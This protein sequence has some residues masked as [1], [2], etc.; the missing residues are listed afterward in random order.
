MKMVGKKQKISKK[1][2]GQICKTRWPNKNIKKK[3]NLLF[4]KMSQK[5]FGNSQYGFPRI[6]TT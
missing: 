5:Q 3:E 1:K 2:I 6:V 4:A